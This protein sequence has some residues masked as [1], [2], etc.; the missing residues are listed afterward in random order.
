MRGTR[1]TFIDAL[2]HARFPP[3]TGARVGRAAVASTLV[4][5]GY[6]ELQSRSPRGRS[7][8]FSSYIAT[9]TGRDLQDVANVRNVENIERLL[10]VIA[11]RSGGL[12]S[13]HGMATDLGI[14]TNTARAHTKILE[15]LFLVAKLQPWHVNLSSRQI[16][17]P[18]L[19]ILDSGLLAFL[20]G[21]NERRI[22]EDG[23]VAGSMLESFVTMELRRQ[24]DSAQGLVSLYHYRDKQQREV[25]VILERHSGEIVGIEVKA[26]ATPNSADFAGLRY[27]RDKLGERFKA[28]AILYT[29]ADTLPFGD[30]L[31]AVPLQGLWAG[32]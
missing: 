12:A 30:R 5:G 1:E 23:P 13:F 2:F 8:F 11:A 28:G 19:C 32:A 3:V 26:T 25:D 24:A 14:D 29:G 17:S 27:L 21:A 16:K 10:Y 31:A 15:D 7:S 6:P 9:I 20:I 22:A 18:K 4:T